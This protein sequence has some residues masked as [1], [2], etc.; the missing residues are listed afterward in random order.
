MDGWIDRLE[1]ARVC[2]TQMF[3]FARSRDIAQECKLYLFFFSALILTYG[4]DGR[5]VQGHWT[6]SLQLIRE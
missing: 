4:L 2:S 3:L 6:R 5:N 1:H